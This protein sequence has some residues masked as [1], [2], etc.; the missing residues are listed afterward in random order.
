MTS[1]TTE[2]TSR[3]SWVQCKSQNPH[4]KGEATPDKGTNKVPRKKSGK[5]EAT[6]QEN[7]VEG[8]EP[9]AVERA[10]A[11]KATPQEHEAPVE[12]ALVASP[13]L[14]EAQVE[15][16]QVTFRQ[17]GPETGA[18][19]SG[20]NRFATSSTRQGT[21]HMEITAGSTTPTAWCSSQMDIR[22]H[23]PSIPQGT[24]PSPQPREA[25]GND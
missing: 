2:E 15:E 5:Q 21:V 3:T 20:V 25:A 4:E 7:P 9:E 11:A 10:Q 16:A 24:V 22:A 8:K 13:P 6:A 17:T 19:P 18:Q 14:Q 1:F 12:E 23:Q